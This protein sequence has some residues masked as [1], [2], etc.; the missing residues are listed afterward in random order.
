MLAYCRKSD[1]LSAE[2]LSD[3]VAD[4]MTFLSKL[5]FFLKFTNVCAKFFCSGFCVVYTILELF[6]SIFIKN[7]GN[8][9]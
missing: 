8:N 2:G 5:A 6:V 4:L 9:S 7:R 1:Q 3:L